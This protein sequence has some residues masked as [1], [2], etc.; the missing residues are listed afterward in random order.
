MS[1]NSLRSSSETH[2]HF[3]YPSSIGMTLEE[4]RAELPQEV[5]VECTTNMQYLNQ[6]FFIR[7]HVYRNDLQVKTFS[8]AEDEIDRRSH[9]IIARVGHFCIGGL[10]LTISKP[11]SPQRLG[12]ERGDFNLHDYLPG[13]KNINYSDISRVAILPQYR[14]SKA[15]QRMLSLAAD[16]A[17]QHN[18]CYIFG[19]SPPAVARRFQR[20]FH[21][22][23]F[24]EELRP[25][26]PMPTGSEN[27]EMKLI[28]QILHLQEA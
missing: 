10:R 21:S 24:R 22:L 12:L 2:P 28:F 1:L 15:V 5:N 11:E 3:S 20:T 14:D 6:Y 8:G 18:C 7:E 25:D 23:G 16:I 4:S 17:L 13:L 26:V 27:K 19:A 9:L